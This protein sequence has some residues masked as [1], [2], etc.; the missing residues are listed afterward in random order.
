[1]CQA[2]F[3]GVAANPFVVPAETRNCVCCWG[4]WA[5]SFE[6]LTSIFMDLKQFLS[7]SCPGSPG[8][9]CVARE[10]WRGR[11]LPGGDGRA[12]RGHRPGRWRCSRR[13][14]CFP[15]NSLCS[16]PVSPSGASISEPAAECGWKIPLFRN[17]NLIMGFQNRAGTFN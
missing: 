13:S 10:D 6:Y 16:S 3:L 4:F 14:F 7:V 17:E 9:R 8:D 12:G 15:R 2:F 5:L 1:M 11:E